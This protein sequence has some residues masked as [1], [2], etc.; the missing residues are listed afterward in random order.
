MGSFNVRLAGI[1]L[2]AAGVRV[3]AAYVNRTYPVVGDA[4]TFHLEAGLLADGQGFRRAGE[5]VP[6]AE[7]PPLHTIVLAAADLLGAHSTAAQKAAMGLLGSVTVGLIGLLG[8]EVAGERAGLVAAG[9]GAVYPMLWLADAAAMSETTSMLLVTA[10]LLT[11]HRARGWRGMAL[12][13]ALIGLA[14]LARGE[15]VGLLGLL[16]VDRRR[17]LA[18]LAAFV[19]VLAPWTIRNALTF[20]APVLISTNANGVFVGANCDRTYDGDLIG[21]WAFSCYGHAPPGDEAQRMVAYRARGQAY[22]REHAGRVPVVVA[23]RVGRLLDVYRPWDQGVF[24]NGTEG[25]DPR[26]SRAGLVMYWAL[27]PF[28]I[29]GAVLLRRR[30]LILLVPVALVLVVGALVYGTTRFRSSAEPSLVVCA[31][32]TLTTRRAARPGARPRG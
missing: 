25:R 27:L 14:A 21:S 1:V 9:L 23:A 22:A 19:L 24:F 11:A 3:L 2:V 20:D 12:L 7:H 4:L 16:L 31:A 17:A 30:G 15:A 6:T 29:A 28:G 26:A 32:V 18:G 8:R 13:G 5:A 10:V